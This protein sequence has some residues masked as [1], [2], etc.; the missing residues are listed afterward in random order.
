MGELQIPNAGGICIEIRSLT[1]QH[2]MNVNFPG[3]SI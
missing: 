2:W 1:F 3:N